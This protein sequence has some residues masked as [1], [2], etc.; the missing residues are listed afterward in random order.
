[1]QRLGC[2]SVQ[3]LWGD[4]MDWYVRPG[5]VE[6]LMSWPGAGAGVGVALVG[7]GPVSSMMRLVRPGHLVLIGGWHSLA[8]DNVEFVR[9]VSRISC[10]PDGGGKDWVKVLGYLIDLSELLP[11]YSYDEGVILGSCASCP[12][13]SELIC[14]GWRLIFRPR[15]WWQV[16]VASWLWGWIC[17]QVCRLFLSAPLEGDGLLD[18][19]R[20]DEFENTNLLGDD[21][22]DL[23]CG[24]MRHQLGDKAA[25]SLGL[26]LTMLHWLLNCGDHGLISTVLRPLPKVDYLV[27]EKW[28]I[29]ID[30]AKRS[31]QVSKRSIKN[32]CNIISFVQNI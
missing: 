23:S 14:E 4:N 21:L 24:E 18:R 27:T 30:I 16:T 17:R 5:R 28:F 3:W 19:M 8:G 2:R 1:M 6:D 31:L 9:R 29:D 22:A 20:I 26:E 15:L 25:V 10:V 32:W 12:L 11:I 7:G 13:P